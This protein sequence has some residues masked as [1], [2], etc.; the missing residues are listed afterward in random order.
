MRGLAAFTRPDGAQVWVNP[1]HVT[2][3]KA[4]HGVTEIH[5]HGNT[6][7]G[8]TES[9]DEAIDHLIETSAATT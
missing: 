6:W 1:D 8:V 5:F 4:E 7:V 2:F 3:V 9:L